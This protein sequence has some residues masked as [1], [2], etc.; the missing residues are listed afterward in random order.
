MREG[1]IAIDFKL[2][3][4]NDDVIHLN[5]F[6]G[7]KNIVLCFYP[8]NHLFVCPSKNVFKMAKSV[9][10]AYPEIIETNSVLFAI[11]IDSLEKQTQPPAR[12]I[13][14]SRTSLSPS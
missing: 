7:K 4:S 11:S 12:W 1:D 3:A 10:S 13:Q 5:S 2:Q 9:I 6:K 14:P 8:K